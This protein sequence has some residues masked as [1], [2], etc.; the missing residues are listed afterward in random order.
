MLPARADVLFRAALPFWDLFLRLTVAA[1]LGGVVGF[2]RE[3][4]EK[5]AVLA[6]TQVGHSQ[7][8]GVRGDR[9]RGARAD[10]RRLRPRA[11]RSDAG[12]RGRDRRH[13]LPRCRQHHSK[14]GDVRGLTT[15]ASVWISGALGAACGVA[16]YRV[17]IVT[18]AF[19]LVTLWLVGV[20]QKRCCTTIARAR[21]PAPTAVQIE[22]R[23]AALPARA[24]PSVV[25]QRQCSEAAT[26]GRASPAGR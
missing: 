26:L 3:R 20:V 7:L 15:A 2:E 24:R 14:P 23:G 13:R 8:G 11:A 1:L 21:T 9:G 22:A 17:A 12:D 6:H 25:K 16:M 5:P 4:H 18:T 19:A 10:F